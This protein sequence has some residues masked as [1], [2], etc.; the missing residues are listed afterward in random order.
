[1][2]LNFPGGPLTADSPLYVQRGSLENIAAQELEKVG[3]L[4]RLQAPK[5]MGK[6]SFLGRLLAQAEA[7]KYRVVTVFFRGR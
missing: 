5:R 2:Q 1:M 7:L 4:I 6:S 3:C